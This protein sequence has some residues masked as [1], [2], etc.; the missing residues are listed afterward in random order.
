MPNQPNPLNFS[1]SDF[2][3][4]KAQQERIQ[5]V[6]SFEAAN[7]A[8]KVLFENLF[9]VP[10]ETTDATKHNIITSALSINSQYEK[11][12]NLAWDI[13]EG[14]DLEK[15]D[16]G[17]LPG[18]PKIEEWAIPN[19]SGMILS[20]LARWS[21]ATNVLEMGMSLGYSTSWLASGLRRGGKIV[22]TEIF[23]PKIEI[24]KKVFE[25]L[26]YQKSIEIKGNIPEVI[27]N[28]SDSDPIDLIF[29]DA[30]KQN[31]HSNFQKLFPLLKLQAIVIVDNVGDYPHFMQ[32]FLLLVKR[33]EEEG[34]IK[35]QL[36]EIDHGLL[37]IYKRP[38]LRL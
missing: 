38:E 35:T 4:Q 9:E 25:N 2:N 31:Y 8:L 29:M 37:V 18:D 24:A 17:L 33:M 27:S 5:A 23:E 19:S 13:P 10:F 3:Y 6:E 12:K 26:G 32:D 20:L 28:W 16:F 7:T 34:L 21:L 36:L 30:D 14:S 1:E 11:Y 15:G 22:T